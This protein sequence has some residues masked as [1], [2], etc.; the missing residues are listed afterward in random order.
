MIASVS[1]KT[2]SRLGVPRIGNNNRANP[3]FGRF[4]SD[5]SDSR[6][7]SP[8]S[9]TTTDHDIQ[10]AALLAADQ[11]RIKEINATV[12]ALKKWDNSIRIRW[13][14]SHRDFEWSRKAKENVRQTTERRQIPQG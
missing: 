8:R 7:T 3:H 5:H 4:G 11:A 10:L 13:A 1:S 2:K 14:S 6:G 12:C 9:D